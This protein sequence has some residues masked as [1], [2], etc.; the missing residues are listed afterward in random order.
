MVVVKVQG[1]GGGNPAWSWASTSQLE[2]AGGR[3]RLPML[4]FWEGISMRH[5]VGVVRT[6][7]TEREPLEKSMSTRPSGWV[8]MR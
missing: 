3:P 5:A 1:F 4:R 2:R 8:A 7:A 6:E